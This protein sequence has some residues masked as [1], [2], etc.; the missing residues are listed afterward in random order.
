MSLV[1]CYPRS[2]GN[3]VYKAL[4]SRIESAIKDG[5]FITSEKEVGGIVCSVYLV[6]SHKT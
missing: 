2:D 6:F 4:I 5:G 3:N 1:F